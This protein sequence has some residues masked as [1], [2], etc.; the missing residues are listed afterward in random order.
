M[1]TGIVIGAGDRGN[2]YAKFAYEVCHIVGVCEPLTY[3]REAFANLYNPTYIFSTYDELFKHDKLADFL[4]V[5]TLDADHYK[6]LEEGLKKGYHILLEKPMASTYR[7]C[8]NMVTLKA[9]Y[10]DQIVLVAHVLR[11]TSFFKKIKQLLDSQKIGKIQHINHLEEVGYFHFAHSYVR[12]N[13]ADETKTSPFILAKTCHDFDILCWL[14]SSQPVDVT[15]KGELRYFNRRNLPEGA[16]SF[17]CKDCAIQN[18]C[19]YSAVRIYS[20]PQDHF[21]KKLLKIANTNSVSEALDTTNYGK[22]VFQLQ[23]NVPD[24]QT[25]Q[26]SYK[27][28][29]TATMTATAFSEKMTRLIT[30]YGSL[31]TIRADLEEEII[32]VHV[33]GN[34]SEIIKLEPSQSGHS[35]GDEGCLHAFLDSIS[36]KDEKELSNI[37]NSFISHKLAFMAEKSRKENKIIHWDDF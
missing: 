35:G 6:P 14:I 28:G 18:E 9:K 27:N 26:I 19:P 13:W 12:G 21:T 36:Q 37:S 5:S 11:Y 15:S 34:G 1:L 29:V 17:N 30:I 16:N 4:I 25:V 32:Q 22:C 7:E 24:T 2:I 33:F 31:G 10:P 20:N 3:K 23:N 8:A